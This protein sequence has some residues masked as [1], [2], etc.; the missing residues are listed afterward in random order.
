MKVGVGFPGG[1]GS[2]WEVRGLKERSVL[3]EQKVVGCVW[4][5]HNI[6]VERT[7]GPEPQ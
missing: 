2:M 1:R 5:E 4:P 6:R 7:G 3:G